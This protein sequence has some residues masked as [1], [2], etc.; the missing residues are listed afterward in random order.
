[1][2]QKKSWKIVIPQF[3]IV[4][5]CQKLPETPK[6]PLTILFLPQKTVIDIF[7]DTPFYSWLIFLHLTSAQS[8]KIAK[9]KKTLW[10]TRRSSSLSFRYGDTVRKKVSETFRKLILWFTEAFVPDRWSAS[11]FIWLPCV[12]VSVQNFSKIKKVTSVLQF[13]FH[14]HQVAMVKRTSC[15]RFIYHS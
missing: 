4:L 5:W 3:R 15:C 7:C 10:N 6:N 1:M 11:F 13:F 9:T 8:Q 12:L 2:R 14:F